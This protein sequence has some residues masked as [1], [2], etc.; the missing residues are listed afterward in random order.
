M[1]AGGPPTTQWGGNPGHRPS[2]LQPLWGERAGGLP[3][4]VFLSSGGPE[5]RVREAASGLQGQSTPGFPSRKG[6]NH[7]HCI[8]Y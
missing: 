4:P 5:W 1:A 6:S 3:V 7:T 8:K 2:A